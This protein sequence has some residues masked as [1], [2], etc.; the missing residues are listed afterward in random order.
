[1]SIFIFFAVYDVQWQC[2]NLPHSNPQHHLTTP[3]PPVTQTAQTPFLQSTSVNHIGVTNV[4]CRYS[5]RQP[6][7][8][9]VRLGRGH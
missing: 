6:R 4:G 1:M 5:L 2:G 8:L 7:R 3:T 9:N